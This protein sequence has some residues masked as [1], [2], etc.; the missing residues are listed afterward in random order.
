M[1]KNIPPVKV[2][3]KSR[4]GDILGKWV[5]VER[6]DGLRF[7]IYPFSRDYNKVKNK[8]IGSKVRL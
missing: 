7:T 6:V 3:A 2:V 5:E 8:K 1:G 4:R